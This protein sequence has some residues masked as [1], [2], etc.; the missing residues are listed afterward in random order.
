[1][2]NFKIFITHDLISSGIDLLKSNNI[3]V[4]KWQGP[5]PI[6]KN[7]LIMNAFDCDALLC[8]VAD[9]IDNEVIDSISNLKIIAN[10]AVGFDN[11]DISHTNVE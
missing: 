7:N 1:M 11:I 4:S 8:S 10:N 5:Y 2:Q 6:T 9:K 3:I